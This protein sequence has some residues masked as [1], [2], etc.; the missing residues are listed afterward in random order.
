MLVPASVDDYRLLARRRL[1]R[2]F[3]DYL[4]GGSYQELTLAANR[5]DLQKIKL[6]QRVLRDVSRCETET[7]VLGQKL[8][9]PIVLAPLGLAGLNARRGEAQAARA[10]QA[11]GVPFCLSTV[12][13]CDI[14]EVTREAGTPPWFQLYMIRDRGYARELLQRVQD[15]GCD[16]LVFTVDLAR[17]G[18]RYRDVRNGMTSRLP[19]GKRLRKALDILAH[20]RWLYD[21]PLRG[22][23]LVFGNLS[24]AVPGARR[25]D[26]F[27]S[28]VNSQ[29]DPSVTWRDLDWVREI[30]PGK[31]VIKGILDPDDARA[32]V[33]T[34]ADAIVVSNHGG[35]Q[36]DSA[37][38][39]I[40]MLPSIVDAVEDRL[41]VLM[42]GGITS[43]QDIAKALALGARA[44]LIGRAWGYG[45]AAAGE[46]GVAE[47]LRIMRGELELTLAL[48]GVC[49]VDDLNPAVLATTEEASIPAQTPEDAA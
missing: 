17:L 7:T 41:E 45:L 26:D 18:M 49:S 28:W 35:R 36:L 21:V 5:H 11:A 47:V 33:A 43:G 19:L 42:D 40:A 31:L 3:F 27:R 16:T 38:S 23:P 13:V 8:A 48:L 37:P 46:Q 34:G 1:P 22:K 25:L 44:C 6:R 12:G 2:T 20:P 24:E 10:A 29:F 4:D 14:E 39:S 15:T 30:W 32:A 9:L